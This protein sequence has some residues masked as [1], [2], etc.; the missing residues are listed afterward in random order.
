MSVA[1]PLRHHWRRVIPATLVVTASLAITACGGSSH[2]SSNSSGSGSSKSSGS[3][4][5]WNTATTASAGGGM[6]ALVKAAK[7]EGT[8]NVIALPPT[9]ANYGEQISTF[10]KKY[11]IK[12]NNRATR[13][14]R[15][16]TRSTRQVARQPEPRA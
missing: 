14:A 9:W 8:L 11:G 13:T 6:A 1:P 15:A 7:A 2:K 3:S 5:G 10:E 12:V 4:A 16:R